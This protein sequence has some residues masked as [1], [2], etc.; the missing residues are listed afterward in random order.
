V[1]TL[2]SRAALA[3]FRV[4]VHTTAMPRNTVYRFRVVADRD[5]SSVLHRLTE[6]DVEIL[7][8]RR[9]AEPSPR[10]RAT[11]DVRQEDPPPEPRDAAAPSGGVVIPFPVRSASCPPGGNP[12]P[13][14]CSSAEHGL[15]PDGNGSAG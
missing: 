2:L 8:I 15:D 7:G 5:P 14:G 3:T 1:A 12:A 11:E 6:C 10:D 4:P 13:G 9:C